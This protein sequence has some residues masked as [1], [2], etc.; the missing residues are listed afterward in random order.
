ML[1]LQQIFA[2]LSLQV[3]PPRQ[4]RQREQYG[5]IGVS[6]PYG[7][8]VHQRVLQV[9]YHQREYRERQHLLQLGLH[10]AVA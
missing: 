9:K 3:L 1:V 7:Q 2:A 8:L 6:N 10:L 4:P 5:R